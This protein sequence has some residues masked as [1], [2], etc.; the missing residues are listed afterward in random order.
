MLPEVA[1][2]AAMAVM[3]AVFFMRP[4]TSLNTMVDYR[5]VRSYRADIGEGGSG[6]TAPAES[7]EDLILQVPVGTTCTR[8]GYRRDSRRPVELAGS[9]LKLPRAVFTAWEIPVLNPVP[10]GPPGKPRLA[11]RV[12]SRSL[13]LEL[14][15][16]ADVGLLGLPNA[17]KSTLIGRC[18]LPSRR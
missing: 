17:G 15:V 13:K 14:K 2:M 10:T 8:R 12:K 1:P 16:L 18:L 7:G 5:F 4:M 3:A 6:A 9:N 11:R